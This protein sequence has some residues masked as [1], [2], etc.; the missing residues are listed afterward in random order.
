M[1]DGLMFPGV[2]HVLVTR[3]SDGATQKVSHISMKK[4]LPKK[5]FERLSHDVFMH[6]EYED[7]LHKVTIAI[8]KFRGP[9]K[10]T[11]I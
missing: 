7:S 10:N 8:Q 6:G 11:F 1:L 5:A 9:Y 2:T 3:K 4:T